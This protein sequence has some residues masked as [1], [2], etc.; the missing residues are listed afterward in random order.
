M[1]RGERFARNVGWGLAGQGAV[2]AINLLVI[3]RLVHGFGIEAYG[4]YLLMQSAAGWVGAL[5][6]GAGAGLV[7]FAAQS[8]A[9]D[10]RGALDDTLRHGAFLIIGGAALGALALW[11]AAPALVGRVFTVPGYYRSHGTWMIRAAA[12]GAVFA[13]VTAWAGA[14][15][16]GLHRFQW[17]SAAA[18]L[19]GML[20]PFGV[21]SALAAGRGLG[22]AAAAFVTVHALVALFCVYGVRR[23]RRAI[24]GRG[25][26]LSFA[27]FGRYSIGFWPGALA[28]LVTG[29]LDRAFVAGLRS[30]SEFTLY[31][32]PASVLARVQTLPATA[33]AALVPVMGGLGRHEGPETPARLYLRASRTLVG[34]IV[35]AY[36]L[37]FCLM[38][39]FLSLWLGGSFGDTSVWPAR[40]LVATQAVALFSFLPTSVAA[41]RKDGWWP[42]AACWLQALVCLALWP[43]MIPRWGL[44]G[45][46]LGGLIAQTLSTVLFVSFV[47]ARLL[48]LTWERFAR[49]TL[50]PAAAGVVVLL[51]LALPLR[52][53]VTGWISF[54]ALCAAAGALYTIVFWR[55]LPKEDRHFLRSRLPF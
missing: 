31:G 2:A 45:A 8:H 37:L 10:Q 16:Q 49:E 22:A 47:H 48:G 44:I 43:W 11:L 29:Q 55:L 23:A 54:F 9:E 41:G 13:S 38:P 32:V 33:S 28:S 51:A 46:A 30:M 14:A 20:I 26:S 25:G 7:R 21:L 5:H 19:Q 42:S 15:F 24:P 18:V 12:L 50:A 4:L 52:V 36:A 40:L 1:S 27:E 35:P 17:Q 3:P 53:R 34:L 6:F 39:Q